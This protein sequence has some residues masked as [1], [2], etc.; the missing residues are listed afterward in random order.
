MRVII[1]LLV[2]LPPLF[3]ATAQSIP[4]QV[5]AKPDATAAEAFTEVF[6]LE[7]L[8]DGRLIATDNRDRAIRLVDFRRGTVQQLGRTGAGPLEYDN[9]FTILRGAGDTLRVV[10][11][12]HRRFAVIDPQGRFVRTELMP[13]ALHSKAQFAPPRESGRGRMHMDL[14]LLEGRD[15]GGNLMV[16][17][18]GTIY[19]WEPGASTL[20]ALTTFQ[21]F[22]PAL[23]R[24]GLNPFPY[25]DA[26]SI[27]HDGRV[28]RISAKDYHVEWLLDGVVVARGPANPATRIRI[29]EKERDA[30]FDELKRR[31]AGGARITGPAPTSPGSRDPALR[32]RVPD[33]AFPS[34]KPLF[35]VR[36]SPTAPNGDLWVTLSRAHNDSV[37]R[38][39]IFGADGKIKGRVQLPPNSRVIAFG[40]THV[41]L[42][43]RDADD[44]E[45]IE[46]H[47]L[48]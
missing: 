48:P 2:G 20:K 29:D 3:G 27:A 42:V 36:Y 21:L 8:P 18:S 9:A 28:A 12:T 43:R 41:Y 25:R 30:Y 34:F 16:P 23:H 19:R 46:R 32:S 35:E 14:M 47:K 45:W 7:E 40:K 37:P 15:R 38:V 1:S 22:E 6:D 4:I 24:Q 5:L 33:S 26:W 17:D 13:A 39:D 31:P 11:S 44:L 10:D